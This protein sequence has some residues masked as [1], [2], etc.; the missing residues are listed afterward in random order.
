MNSDPEEKRD[1]QEE[2]VPQTLADKEQLILR[3]RVDIRKVYID[4]ISR[5]RDAA[6]GYENSKPEISRQLRY[7]ASEYEKRERKF[8]D[9]FN[10]AEEIRLR[11]VI[12]LS[13]LLPPELVSLRY[14]LE[15]LTNRYNRICRNSGREIATIFDRAEKTCDR[16][17]FDIGMNILNQILQKEPRNFQTLLLLAY[18]YVLARDDPRTAIRLLERALSNL[19]LQSTDH[20]KELVLVFLAKAHELAGNHV[21][22]V[23]TLKRLQYYGMES[24]SVSYNIA[25]NYSLGGRGREAMTILQEMMIQVPETFSY[26]FID[27]AFQSLLPEIEESFIAVHNTWDDQVSYLMDGFGKLR[28]YLEDS[29]ILETDDELESLLNVLQEAETVYA[30]HCLSSNL[31]IARKY[32]PQLHPILANKIR[33]VVSNLLDQKTMDMQTVLMLQEEEKLANRHM[34]LTRGIIITTIGLAAIITAM[35][36]LNISLN[37][38]LIVAGLYGM[39]GIIAVIVFLT[40]PLPEDGMDEDIEMRLD[41]VRNNLKEI[42]SLRSALIEFMELRGSLRIA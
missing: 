16:G 14:D 19:P 15:R 6:G 5:L 7:T 37:A 8:Y 13:N 30:G 28:G 39:L 40:R 33:N 23:M 17:D 29:R 27:E 12:Y 22:A 34:L 41:Q 4:T 25:R 10:K 26:V 32:L 20:Y 11:D 9:L 21:N 1:F 2:H 36:G 31:L 35:I 42:E 18:G 38:I 3:L 24:A